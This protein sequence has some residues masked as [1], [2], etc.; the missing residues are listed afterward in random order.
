MNAKYLTPFLVGLAVFLLSACERLVIDPGKSNEPVKNF[1]RLWQKVKDHYPYFSFKGANWDSLYGQYRPRI[2]E[3]TSDAE[4]FQVITAM[5]G[6]LKDGHI[7]V[8]TPDDYYS[9]DYKAGSPA[10]YD[11]SLVRKS[12]LEKPGVQYHR[13]GGFTYAIL[14]N[15]I[16]YIHYRTFNRDVSIIDDILKGFDQAKVK[17]LIMDVRSNG[18]GQIGNVISLTG[19]F[20]A[21]QLNVGYTVFKNGPGPDDFTEPLQIKVN[22]E[23]TGWTKPVVLLTNR[24]CFSACNFFA[25]FMRQLPNVTTLGD[26]TGGGGAM[27]IEYELPNGW[28]Y[29]VSTS[30]FY[31]ADGFNIEGGVPP[32]VRVE[33]NPEHAKQGTDDLIEQATR[34]IESK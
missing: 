19:R 26:M 20:T 21:S 12:Y 28:R 14:E 22:P 9:Y 27:P 16:G 1:D 8:Y 30:A 18:G 2:N 29:R 4:L 7:S 23:G 11:S 17:G 34:L 15:G 31:G 10:N 33:M 5:L 32:D 25:E 3:G 24:A 13:S 6:Q